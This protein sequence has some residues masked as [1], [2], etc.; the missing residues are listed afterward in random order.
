M[1]AGFANSLYEEAGASITTDRGSLLKG[2]DIVLRVRKPSVD[3]VSSLKQGAIHVSYLDP[4][5]E[6][7]LVD[8]LTEAGI[9]SISMEMIP[10]TTRAQKMDALSSQA[11]LAGY[12]M[13]IQAASKLDRIPVSYTHLTLP[14]ILRV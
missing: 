1:H 2:A 13:V 7:V 8:K 4:Y 14:T 12:V 6:G 9:T 11:N 5:N 10:R 3:E